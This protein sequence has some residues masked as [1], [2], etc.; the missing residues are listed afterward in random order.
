MP[1]FK[2]LH[3]ISKLDF[4]CNLLKLHVRHSVLKSDIR[5]N[6]IAS[7][8]SLD[9]SRECMYEMICHIMYSA[10]YVPLEEN[11]IFFH[12]INNFLWVWIRIQTYEKHLSCHIK[13]KNV[14]CPKVI[15]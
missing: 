8:K 1:S 13:K 11:V 5:C 4:R 12:Q 6:I 7:C 14:C 10:H 2:T 9:Q 3:A 15:K